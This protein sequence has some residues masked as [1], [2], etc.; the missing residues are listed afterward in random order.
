VLSK[1]AGNG[2]PVAGFA[3]ATVPGMI[4]IREKAMPA[5]QL[6]TFAKSVVS[7]AHEFDAKVLV[8]SN[9]ALAKEVGADGVHL[10]S[11]QLTMLNER[12]DF[13]LVGASTHT[14]AELKRAA[15]LKCD[16]AVLGPVKTTQTH[17]GLAAM[18]WDRFA[19]M[20][21]AAPLP[22]YALGGLVLNDVT[23]AMASG[24]HGVALQRGIF[25]SGG[26]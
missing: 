1:N 14:C 13:S 16:F 10:T 23:Q 4:Q 18:G 21:E 7:L 9:V 20:V 26:A 5:A 3:D 12:P 22:C 25:A 19:S 24:A 2:T 6:K 8:N 15:A 17:P 11:A